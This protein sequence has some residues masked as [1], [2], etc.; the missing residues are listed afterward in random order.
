MKLN[1]FFAIIII[2]IFSM[3][4]DQSYESKSEE[5]ETKEKELEQRESEIREKEAMLSGSQ[6][7]RIENN[8]ENRYSL[9]PTRTLPQTKS[10]PSFDQFLDIYLTKGIGRKVSRIEKIGFKISNNMGFAIIFEDDDSNRLDVSVES[11]RIIL[12]SNYS[13]DKY[14]QAVKNNG[15]ILAREGSKQN[16]YGTNTFKTYRNLDTEI[17]I[18]KLNEG[19]YKNSI[20][21][22]S[23]N[24]N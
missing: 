14:E 19:E 13:I 20:S 3:S 22:N 24:A 23:I 10:L 17:F 21:I 12:Y 18:S 11:G 6:N 8:A 1:I 16:I 9:P 4:C 7:S 5:L 2:S 15:F